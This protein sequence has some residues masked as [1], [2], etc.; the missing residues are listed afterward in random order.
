[1]IGIPDFVTELCNLLFLPEKRRL[2]A[3]LDLIEE[4]NYELNPNATRAFVYRGDM[5]VSSKATYRYK[6]ADCP[7]LR[8]QLYDQM[9]GYKLDQT[10]I[11]NDKKA[12]GQI[13][14]LMLYQCNNNQEIRDTLPECLVALVPAFNLMRRQKNQGFMDKC[15]PRTEEQYKKLLPKIEFYAATHLIY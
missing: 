8:F 14:N 12:I 15:S 6:A 11:L 7:T 3:I 1:M 10:R 13:L 9:V 2:T 5:Y 4:A